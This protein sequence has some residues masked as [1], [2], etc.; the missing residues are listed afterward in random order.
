MDISLLEKSIITKLKS[1]ITDYA[2]EL[3]PDN[4]DNYRLIHPKGSVLLNYGGSSFRRPQNPEAIVQIRE[5]YFDFIILCRNLRGNGGCYDLLDSVKNA[6]SGFKEQ[7]CDPFYPVS[8]DISSH[9]DGIWTYQI[10]FSTK[11]KYTEASL[12][13]NV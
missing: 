4:P 12:N 8:E 7:G 2:V 9:K 13:Y 11:V 3:Y 5:I 1:E 6:I 10:R